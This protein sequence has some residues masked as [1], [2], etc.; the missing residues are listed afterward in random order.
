MCT[1]EVFRKNKCCPHTGGPQKW[2]PQ[3]GALRG[4]QLARQKVTP[5]VAAP[6]WAEV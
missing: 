2:E 6:A 4:L 5:E 3:P 1:R